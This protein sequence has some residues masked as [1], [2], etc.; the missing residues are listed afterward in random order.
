[1]SFPSSLLSTELFILIKGLAKLVL[2]DFNAREVKRIERIT[3]RCGEFEPSVQALDDQALA[4][5]TAEFKGRLDRGE[6]LDELLPEAFAVV[7]E[8]ARRTIGLRHYDV[9][10]IGGVVLHEGNI[11]EMKTGEGKTLVA[12]PPCTSTLPPEKERTWSR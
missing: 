11:A 2:G 3:A 7:R 4:G 10:M 1:V 9:Q 6:P 5:K 12:T 8:A